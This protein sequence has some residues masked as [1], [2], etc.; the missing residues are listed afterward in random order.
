[1]SA[2]GPALVAAAVQTAVLAKAP[3]RTVQ[4]GASAVAGV[5]LGRPTAVR[6]SPKQSQVT[7]GSQCATEPAAGDSPEELLAKLRSARSAQRRRKKERR[8]AA[9]Q[10]GALT[11]EEKE[12]EAPRNSTSAEQQAARIRWQRGDR[13]GGDALAGIPTLQAVE[14]ETAHTSAPLSILRARST[15][16]G[17]SAGSGGTEKSAM[18]C[19]TRDSAFS[20]CKPRGRLPE[21]SDRKP[22]RLC[23]GRQA[24]C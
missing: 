22:D 9:R 11:L 5:V 17:L 16:R 14:T 6:P 20:A 7:A 1:M 3:R 8:R 24:D 13:G 10:Q 12:E 19:G 18:T 15:S 4:A 23:K 21:T 2:D